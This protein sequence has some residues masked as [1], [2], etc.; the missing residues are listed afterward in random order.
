MRRARN[1]A[2][3]AVT[4]DEAHEVLVVEE[5]GRESYHQTLLPGRRHR[6][7]NWAAYTQAFEVAEVIGGT[8]RIRRL[9]KGGE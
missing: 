1:Q 5:D 6:A 4:F 2:M 8:V 9:A 7:A 3:D